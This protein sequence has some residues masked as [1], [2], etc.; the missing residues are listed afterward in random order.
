MACASV[1][2]DLITFGGYS[3]S[4]TSKAYIFQSETLSW[5]HVEPAG[6]APRARQG[7]TI[8]R[9]SHALILFGGADDVQLYNDVHVLSLKDQMLWTAPKVK[10]APTACVLPVAREGHA[11]SL[12]RKKL[13]IFGGVGRTGRV[14]HALDDLAYLDVATFTWHVPRAQ[15]QGGLISPPARTLHSMVSIA[16]RLVLIGGMSSPARRSLNAAE[17]FDTESFA[18]VQPLA[19]GQTPPAR[20]SAALVVHGRSLVLVG[21][22]DER[23]CSSDVHLMKSKFIR[24]AKH[25]SAATIAVSVVWHFKAR[26]G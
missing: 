4:Y 2:P 17:I 18:W 14:Y 25:G 26:L 8:T 10:C 23:R 6:E 16:G 12:V 13:W 11:A 1:G 9:W 5:R 3:G 24:S 22:C 19:V 21:G 15:S 7:A 20:Q